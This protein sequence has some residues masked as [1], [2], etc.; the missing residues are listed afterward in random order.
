[1]QAIDHTTVDFEDCIAFY[2]YAENSRSKPELARWLLANP[3]VAQRAQRHAGMQQHLQHHYDPV[4]EEPIPQ[5]LLIGNRRSHSRWPAR[6]AVAATLVVA[7]S[8]AWWLQA[9]DALNN[10]VRPQA[11]PVVQVEPVHEQMTNAGDTSI[12]HP[13]LSAHGYNLVATRVIQTSNTPTVRFTYANPRGEQVRIYAQPESRQLA[14]TNQAAS[15]VSQVH[16]QHDG[17]GY[18]MVGRLPERSLQVLA[19][20]AKN[21]A[22]VHTVS[23]QK[24]DQQFVSESNTVPVQSYQSSPET[25]EV[26]YSGFEQTKAVDM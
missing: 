5:R 6:M 22:P 23:Q 19:T 15:V 10:P 9:G 13:N 1:M 26:L 21:K 12:Q 20:S 18:T 3:D 25:P 16:W 14:H 4:L 17:V 7:V 8:S 2:K 24:T 11:Q